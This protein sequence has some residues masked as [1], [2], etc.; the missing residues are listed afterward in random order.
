MKRFA[1]ITLLCM[2][3][4][5]WNAAFADDNFKMVPPADTKEAKV[6]SLPY[7]FSSEYFGA[8]V[9]Y[10]YAVVGEPQPQ[11]AIL[12]TV[13][14]GTKGSAM[15]FIMGQDL[16]LPGLDRLFIDPIASTGYFSGA[17][18]YVNGNPQFAG[19]QAGNN[20]SSAQ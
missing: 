3:L 9:G 2:I 6:L 5:C 18:A 7:A 15:L 12:A 13:M 11:S 20:N 19:Q 16:R 4:S 8:S 1:S 17:T 14:A 10:V